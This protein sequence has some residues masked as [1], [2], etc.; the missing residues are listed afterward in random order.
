MDEGDTLV[1]CF[2]EFVDS[3]YVPPVIRSLVIGDQIWTLS[4]EALQANA[5]D[6]LDREEFISLG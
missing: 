2:P 1:V 3:E 5:I 6:D 4:W